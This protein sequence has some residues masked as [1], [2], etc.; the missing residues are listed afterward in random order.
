MNKY[1]RYETIPVGFFLI[2]VVVT[3]A[4]LVYI[5]ISET[6]VGLDVQ[7]NNN[8]RWEIT[9]VNPVGWAEQHNIQK[10]DIVLEVNGQAPSTFSSV[11]Q[12]GVIGKMEQMRV[13]RDGRQLEFNVRIPFQFSTFLYHTLLPL[14]VFLI[15]L[16]FSLYIYWKKPTEPIALFLI[17]FLSAVG[18]G[19]LSA[20]ASARLDT[21]AR[22]LNSFSLMM[23]PALFL[24][25]HYQ[26]FLKYRIQLIHWKLLAF[27]YAV[28]ISIVFLE[29]LSKVI[30][31]GGMYEWIRDAQLALFSIEMLFG[32]CVLIY[33]YFKFRS[34]IHKTVFQNTIFSVIVS[35][36]PFIFLTALPDTLFDIK[37][38]PASVTAAFLTVLPVFFLYFVLTNKV[39]DIDFINSRLRYYAFQSLILTG[40]VSASV[41]F[42]TNLTHIQWA[43]FIL[44]IY[45]SFIIFFYLEDKLNIRGLFKDQHDYEISLD[46]FSQ[47]VAKILKK[48]ELND[49]LIQ[50]IK[51][52]LPVQHTS[53]ITFSKQDGETRLSAGDE[54]C[55]QHLIKK[56]LTY[57]Q[58]QRTIGSQFKIEDGICSIIN[59]Q[60]DSIQVL[61]IEQKVNHTPFNKDERHWIS[62]LVHYTSIVYENFQLLENVTEELNYSLYN[63]QTMPPWMLRLLFRLSEKERARLS[64]DLHDSALQEQLI[65]YRKVEEMLAQKQLTDSLKEQLSQLRQGLLSVVDQIRETCTLLRPPFLKDTGIAEALSYLVEHYQTRE[66]FDIQFSSCDFNSILGDEQALALYRIV[67]ELLN[68]AA[69]HSKAQCV[70]IEVRNEGNQFI[71]TYSD[72]GVGLPSKGEF[73][74]TQMMGMTGIRQRVNSIHGTI[75]I[76]SPEGS[77]LEVVI[78]FPSE[79]EFTNH[80][81]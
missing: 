29:G 46:R 2:I 56:Q 65:W 75:E 64:Y 59:E 49:R 17:A 18:F 16:G 42:F 77:G 57:H 5:T 63:G 12:Y 76:L 14:G 4:Y 55:P 70:D 3:A 60:H 39:F 24:H 6:Y 10:G 8:G 40:I 44:L 26:Y 67:Q 51:E 58:S 33:Y 61:W 11:Q 31:T 54:G 73:H 21:F 27:V 20:G 32:F 78:L 36:F 79:Q 62:I 53:I 34:T 15:L 41:V 19:Y 9:N 50:E 7:Q 37:L 25:F 69:K 38:L 35:F 23:V 80:F 74:S 52:V 45:G 81:K 30:Y 68:N 47:D 72:D 71:M 13:L 1:V 66:S 22:L 48:D 28:N 43:R